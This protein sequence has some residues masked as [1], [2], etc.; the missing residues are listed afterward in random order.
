MN[1]NMD[2]VNSIKDKTVEE[3]KN[4]LY[5]SLMDTILDAV[6]HG[7]TALKDGKQS[8]QFM[9]DKLDNAKTKDEILQFLFDLST[10]WSLY[11]PI[12]IK[13]KYS[14]EEEKDTKKMQ[15]LK[16]KLYSFIKPE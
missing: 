12:Y 11:S 1:G 9:L 5:D 4:E 7:R 13:M 15:E 3:I 10:K 6:I 14:V 2:T 8:A 16:S